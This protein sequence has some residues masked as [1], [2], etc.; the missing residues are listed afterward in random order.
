VT[1]E[2]ISLVRLEPRAL[3]WIEVWSEAGKAALAEMVGGPLPPPNWIVTLGEWRAEGVEP[4]VWRLLGVAE[5]AEFTVVRLKEALASDGAVIDLSGA[6][7]VLALRGEHWRE[8]LMIGGVFD[9]ES[10]SFTV[11]AAAGTVL[12]HTP[13]RYGVDETG[14]E[15]ACALSRLDDLAHHLARAVDRINRSGF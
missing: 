2:A 13:V 10:L 7:G 8:A 5:A 14:V 1:P 15:I 3:L 4:G 12:H 9:A 11:G 6:E